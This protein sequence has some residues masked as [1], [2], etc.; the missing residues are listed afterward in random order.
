MLLK[1]EYYK[2]QIGKTL[3]TETHFQPTIILAQELTYMV[4]FLSE[5]HLAITIVKELLKLMIMK[6][7]VTL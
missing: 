2:I 5:R 6:D 4:K 1:V 7:L 3:Y